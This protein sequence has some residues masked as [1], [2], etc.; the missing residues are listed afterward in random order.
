MEGGLDINIRMERGDNDDVQRKEI[1]FER[2]DHENKRDPKCQKQ[3][4]IDKTKVNGGS[5]T[6]EKL[7][8]FSQ[9]TPHTFNENNDL[10]DSDGDDNESED[11]EGNYY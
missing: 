1:E 5:K 9:Q 11:E 3:D 10:D 2:V 4:F 6:T 8:R 7:Q